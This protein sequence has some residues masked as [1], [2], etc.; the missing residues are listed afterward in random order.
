M[1]ETCYREE[2]YYLY[3]KSIEAMW[4]SCYKANLAKTELVIAGNIVVADGIGTYPPTF[5]PL[6]SVYHLEYSFSFLSLLCKLTRA[7]STATHTLP[8]SSFRP[9]LTAIQSSN[10]TTQTASETSATPPPPP[11]RTSLT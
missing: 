3:A 10:P 6:L 4:Q 8:H 7:Y 9:L 2:S 11:S 1:N 5:P